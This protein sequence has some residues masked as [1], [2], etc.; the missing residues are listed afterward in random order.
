[1]CLFFFQIIIGFLNEKVLKMF[2]II[3]FGLSVAFISLLLD[4]I[5]FIY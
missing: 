5:L 3:F 1:M 4:F 2:A